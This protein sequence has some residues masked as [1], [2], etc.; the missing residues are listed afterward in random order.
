[1]DN[2]RYSRIGRNKNLEKEVKK[3]DYNTCSVKMSKSGSI[4]DE[5][6]QLLDLGR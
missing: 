4:L 1:M 6:L 3:I 5:I 2:K